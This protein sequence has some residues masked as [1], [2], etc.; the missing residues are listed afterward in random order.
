MMEPLVIGIAG[1]TGSGKST[2]A[3]SIFSSL[4]EKNISILE[5][6]AYYKDQSNI[7]F[8]KRVQTNYDHPLAFDTDLLIEH[9]E[10]LRNNIQIEKPIY[11]FEKHTRKEETINVIPKEIL[12]VE[13][14]MVLEDPRLRDLMDVKIF[15]DTDADVRIIRRITRDIEERGRTLESVIEQYFAT[16]KPAHDQFVEPSKKYADIIIP[17]GGLNKVAIDILVSNIENKLSN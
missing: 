1:G 12:I 3:G 4:P 7:P 17:E 15:V 8:E 13:G 9:I 10:A 14:I 16:V 6:D 11:D 5:Q 2:V